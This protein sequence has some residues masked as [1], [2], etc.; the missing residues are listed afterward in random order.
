[1]SDSSLIDAYGTLSPNTMKEF[2]ESDGDKVVAMWSA[3]GN[4][5]S[6]EFPKA[7]A[8]D[9]LFRTEFS[10]QFEDGDEV[11]LTIGDS[12][13]RTSGADIA[14]FNET[15]KESHSARLSITSPIFRAIA[16]AIASEG[17]LSHV[18]KS[19]VLSK[20]QIIDFMN[21]CLDRWFAESLE[22]RMR[23][24]MDYKDGDENRKEKWKSLEELVKAGKA[25]LE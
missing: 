9:L 8:V 11:F 3:D 22:G 19:Y 17:G 24:D 6:Q 4:P 18:E 1:M 25:V 12:V 10:D 23:F 16:C 21:D 13:L 15:H 5:M 14:G 2:M 7:K 20:K